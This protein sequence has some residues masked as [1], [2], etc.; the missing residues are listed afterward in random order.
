MG[1]RPIGERAAERVTVR[2]PDEIVVRVDAYAVTNNI[3][4]RSEAVRQL[5]LLG[6]T[7]HSLAEHKRTAPKR[8]K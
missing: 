3:N 7:A 5:L 6:L 8:K 4:D 2:I 1:R